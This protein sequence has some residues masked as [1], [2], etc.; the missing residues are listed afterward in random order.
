MWVR[1]R[2]PVSSQS[3]TR[4]TFRRK[5]TCT[6][7]LRWRLLAGWATVKTNNQCDAK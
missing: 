3:N 5:C 7:C 6:I 1:A 4:H 2:V